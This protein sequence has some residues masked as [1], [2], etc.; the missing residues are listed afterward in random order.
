MSGL[1]ILWGFVEIP[2]SLLTILDDFK[3]YTI[4]P[5]VSHTMIFA[6]KTTQI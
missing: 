5:F 2:E 3:G 1:G 6:V 4:I